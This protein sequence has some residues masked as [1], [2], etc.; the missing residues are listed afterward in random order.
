MDIFSI[1]FK[2]NPTMINFQCPHHRCF[3]QP[4]F[5]FTLNFLTPR[6][7]NNASVSFCKYHKINKEKMK[8]DLLASELINNLSKE[9]V[10]ST[11]NITPHCPHFSTNML[12]YTPNTP[13]QSTSQDGL[14]KL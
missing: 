8:A 6:S 7:Q 4:F 12:H 10:L 5:S 13:R 3:F 2:P 9:P 14:T 1:R 11:N